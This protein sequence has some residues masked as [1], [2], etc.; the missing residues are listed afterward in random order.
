MLNR[1]TDKF[2]SIPIW[3]QWVYVS[4]VLFVVMYGAWATLRTPPVVPGQV[5]NALPARKLEGMPTVAVQPLQVIVYRDRAKVV[6]RLGLPLETGTV[7]DEEVINSVDVP[8]LK[9]GGSSTV[10]L[11]TS[12][13][14]SRTVIKANNAPWF[15]FRKDLSAGVGMGVGTAGKT[16]AGR[17]R[18]DMVQIK[19]VVLSV[20]GEGNYAE[21]R[22]D[23]I[24]GRAMIWATVPIT[25]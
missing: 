1:L 18:L 20:E 12:S 8:P 15:Q 19:S 5:V 11:N 21:N 25:Q 7:P 23:P 9:Y 22:K 3:R 4:I 6:E 10:F 14:Q 13:G 24:E 2:S 17:L 16:L